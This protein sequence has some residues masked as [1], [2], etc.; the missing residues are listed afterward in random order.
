MLDLIPVKAKKVTIRNATFSKKIVLNF[1]SL[2]IL[3]LSNNNIT[4]ELLPQLQSLSYLRRLNLRQNLISQFHQAFVGL[5]MLKILEVQVNPVKSIT[6]DTFADLDNLILLNLSHLHIEFISQDAFQ[7]LGS[8]QILDLSYNPLQ[9]L[10]DGSFFTIQNSLL[11]LHIIL[12]STPY[13]LQRLVNT[14]PMLQEIYVMDGV[15]CEYAK[16]TVRCVPSH[17]YKGQCCKLINNKAME[18]VLL[19]IGLLLLTISTFALVFLLQMPLKRLP[20]LLICIVNAS[21]MCSALYPFYFFF[22]NKYYGE[23][24]A[25]HKSLFVTSFHCRLVGTLVFFFQ[26]M[27]LYSLIMTA[28][29]RLVAIMDPFRHLALSWRPFVSSVALVTIALI[30]I[31]AY[32]L[33]GVGTLAPSIICNIMPLGSKQI[34]QFALLFGSLILV[35]SLLHGGVALLHFL[36]AY[37]LTKLIKSNMKASDDNCLKKQARRNA[38]CLGVCHV[39]F[40]I[41]FFVLQMLPMQG[42]YLDSESLV[43]KAVLMSFELVCPP[44]YTFNKRHFRSQFPRKCQFCLSRRK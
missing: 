12:R 14:L 39:S 4:T 15:F 17:L 13:K 5:Q 31:P 29:L 30:V 22:A 44:I 3:D 18:Y 33:F 24:F 21:S 7:N 6:A 23:S 9:G 32:V 43:L 2:L 20:K 34:K 26:Y 27:L 40:L 10:D 41:I 28:I 38:L 37:R 1:P 35:G 16:G 11:V 25:F 8:L 19:T 36:T 42:G